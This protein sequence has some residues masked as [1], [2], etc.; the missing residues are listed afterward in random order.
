MSRGRREPLD[1]GDDFELA[2]H[3]GVGDLELLLVDEVEGGAAPEVGLP[4]HHGDVFEGE[5]FGGVVE[6]DAVVDGFAVV[7]MR[8]RATRSCMSWRYSPG[9][10]GFLEAVPEVGYDVGLVGVEDIREEAAGEVRGV[11]GFGVQGLGGHL[12]EGGVAMGDA[13]IGGGGRGGRGRGSGRWGT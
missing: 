11:C 7:V 10:V 13:V 2:V 8:R 12:S 4:D 5:F 1:I 6:E 3:L 9:G